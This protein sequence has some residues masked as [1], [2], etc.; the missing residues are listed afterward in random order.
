MPRAGTPSR[1]KGSRDDPPVVG[2]SDGSSGRS[3][4]P[5]S[6]STSAAAGTSAAS[7]HERAL[8]GSALRASLDLDPDLTVVAVTDETIVLRADDPASP[9][10]ALLIGSLFG[11]RWE[12]GHGTV[13]EVLSTEGEDVARSFTLVEGAPPVAGAGAELD[14]RVYADRTEAGVEEGDVPI[15]EPLG[16]APAWFVHARGS[17]WVVVVHGNSMSQLDNLRWLPG[18]HDA[19][20]PTLTITYRNDTGAPEDPS[21]LLRYGETEWADLEAA[22]RYALDHGSD[23]VVLFGDSMGGGI[24]ESFL[25][26]SDL[27]EDVRA[28][29]LDAPML[30]FSRTVDDNAAREP[31]VGPITVPPTLTWTAKLFTSLRDDVEWSALNYLSDPAGL[32]SVPTLIVHGD[33]DL[34]VPIA[35]SRDAA[36]LYPR[37]SRCTSARARITSSAGTSTPRGWTRSSRG[38]CRPRSGEPGRPA[39]L[40]GVDVVGVPQREPDVVEPLHQAP[41][42]ELLHVEGL[43]ERRARVTVAPI[44]VDDDRAWSVVE[45]RVH[46]RRTDSSRQLDREQPDLQAVVPE[47]VGEARRDHRAEPVRPRSPTARAR[48]WSPHPKFGAGEQDRRA[49]VAAGRSSTNVRVLAP[50]VEQ[51]RAEP[52][53]LDPLQVLR[54]DDLVGVDVGAVQRERGALDAA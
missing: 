53:A 3:C 36:R 24:I 15:D 18:L 40:V 10:T 49:G 47:D 28:V 27:D 16:A 43:V 46:Q 19:G 5:C 35:T 25:L 50:L 6:S 37:R 11:L 26:R 54:R 38:S 32:G 51:E 45:H 13:G 17:T 20:Y 42:R 29:V 23:G 33:H 14:P 2:G 31:L 4:S 9:P 12:G 34:T 7:I 30:D 52:R 8:S 44:Q 1:A 41:P 21:G 39:R 48:G 22:V